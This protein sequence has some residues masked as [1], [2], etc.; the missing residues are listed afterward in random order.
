VTEKKKYR[1]ANWYG[2]NDK[3][4]FIHRSWMKN[5]GFPGH[6]FD[7]AVLLGGCD[8]TTPGQL[9]GSASVDIPDVVDKDTKFVTRENH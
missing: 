6:A 2:K 5:Q 9:M 8:K 7:G 4:G 3:D 1:L